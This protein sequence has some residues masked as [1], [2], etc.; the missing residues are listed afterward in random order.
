[1]NPKWQKI[2][3][4]ELIRMSEKTSQAEFAEKLGF[5]S[6]DNYRNHMTRFTKRIIGKI[7][8]I[9]GVDITEE[10]IIYLHHEIRKFKKQNKE[11]R[12]YLKNLKSSDNDV[13]DVADII[14][15][16]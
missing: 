1:M 16:M 5:N 8:E 13:I 2:N 14:S 11:L 6:K 4:V 15:D 9:Y 10:I 12:K 7:N 3:P